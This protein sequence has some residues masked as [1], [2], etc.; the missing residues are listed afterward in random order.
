MEK[1]FIRFT[2]VLILILMLVS[3]VAVG[4]TVKDIE[5]DNN[6]QNPPTVPDRPVDPSEVLPI[7]NI[8]MTEL[9][10]QYSSVGHGS[11]SKN[12]DNSGNKLSLYDAKNKSEV[13]F[14]TGY[15]A[16]A[17][18][19]IVIDELAMRGFYNFEVTMGINKTARVNNTVTSVTF[20]IYLDNKLAFDSGELNA[21]SNYVKAKLDI[22]NVDRITLL[23]DDMGGNGHDHAVWANGFFSYVGE[24]KPKIIADDIEFA[25][26]HDV[27]EANILSNVRAYDKNGKDISSKVTYTTDY[28]DG[29]VG[30]FE[31]TFSVNDNGVVSKKTVK[32]TVFSDKKFISHA[33]KEYLTQPFANHVY[34]GRNLLGL[35]SRKAY[36]FIMEGLLKADISNSNKTTMTFNLQD[37]GIY[38]YPSEVTKIKTYL[39]FDESRLYFIYNWREDYGGGVWYTKKNGLVDTVTI[40][41][42]NGVNDYYYGHNNAKVYQDAENKISVY[43]DS[44]TQDMSQA[45]LHFAIHDMY[46]KPM[47]YANVNYADGFYGAFI[48]NQAICSGYSKGY[49][50]LSQRLGAKNA[51]VI[52]SA[53]GPHAWNDV[54]IDGKWY[55]TDTTWGWAE[56]FS[57]LGKDYFD[58]NGRYENYNYSVM[59]KLNSKGYDRNLAKYPTMSID[60]RIILNQGDIFNVSSMVHIRSNVA[61]KVSLTNVTYKGVVD[62]NTPGEY[63]ITITAINSLGNKAVKDVVVYVVGTPDKLS[64]LEGVAEGS[65]HMQKRKVSLYQN[66][67]EIEFQD[68]IALKAN[69]T[70]SVTYNI[71][72]MGYKYFSAYIGIDKKIRDNTAY[73]HYANATFKIYADGVLLYEKKNVGWKTDMEAIFVKLPNNVK[74][75][76]ISVTDTSGQGE[77]GWGNCS[78]YK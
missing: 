19:V 62:T 40:K 48:T 24:I 51:Y 9:A 67:K 70:I 30:D 25:S 71:E 72:N 23:A 27:T 52:G 32:L 8:D 63:K 4:C 5:N 31:V 50:Y 39:I 3:I 41:L 66:G 60:N 15:F 29:K 64:N 18:S 2:L 17:Y 45:Q 36:D 58:A 53:G 38:I 75:L 34:Y 74:N 59:P 44:L 1:R 26:V 21:Y 65:S 7:N 42:Y 61:D 14:E 12:K 73:G 55:M 46:L 20:R 76:K 47:K 77:T 22:Q 69:G 37:N 78:L 68:G 16:H 35:E 10:Y 43:F 57:M 6:N 11:L 33:S 54:F 56:N 28:V 13:E 49:Q